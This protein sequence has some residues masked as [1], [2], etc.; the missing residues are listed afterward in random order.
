MRDR[1]YRD[2]AVREHPDQAVALAYGQHP[3]IVLF[4]QLRSTLERIFRRSDFYFT[5]HYLINVHKIFSLRE[6]EKKAI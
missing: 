2:V 5:C 4:H 1:A 6:S 3:E